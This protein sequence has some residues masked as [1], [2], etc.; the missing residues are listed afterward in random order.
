MVGLYKVGSV[1]M[2]TGCQ[3]DGCCF[4]VRSAA[5][6]G[7]ETMN[8]AVPFLAFALCVDSESALATSK[9]PCSVTLGSYLPGS[10]VAS[11]L[12]ATPWCVSKGSSR[13]GPDELNAS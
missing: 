11:A 1:I 8:P 12:D 2:A 5:E 3:L 4:V 6:A 13:D 9:L 10:G 7:D